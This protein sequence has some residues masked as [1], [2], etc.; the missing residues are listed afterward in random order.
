MQHPERWAL[1]AARP[2]AALA[3]VSRP[4]VWLLTRATDLTVRLFGGDP[5]R[6]RPGVT[7][8]ELRDMVAL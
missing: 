3:A 5:G 7:E 8:R 6:H 1:L 4:A 2:L